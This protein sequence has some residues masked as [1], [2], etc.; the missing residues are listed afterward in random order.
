MSARARV[1]AAVMAV[2]IATPAAHAEEKATGPLV[3]SPRVIAEAVNAAIAS[4]APGL[5]VP[6]PRAGSTHTGRRVAFTAL[7]AVGGFF[8]GAFLGAKIDR[9]IHDCNCDDPGFQG[10]L[11]G[12]PVGA[13]AG[14][15]AGWMLSR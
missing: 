14:G 1:I 10:F 9:S 4:P 3:I 5:G 13:I 11:I 2:L 7:G 8:G 6:Q 12:M 15:V